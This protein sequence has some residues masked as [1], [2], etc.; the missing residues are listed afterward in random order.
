MC[1]F[2][3]IKE[4]LRIDVLVEKLKENKNVLIDIGIFSL[5]GFVAGYLVKRYGHYMLAIALFIVGLFV[6]QHVNLINI[7]LNWTNVEQ[8]FGIQ[9]SPAVEGGTVLTL[10]WEWVKANVVRMVSLVVGF[11]VGLHVG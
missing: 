8:V 7:S 5:A 3:K 4:T 2:E 1:W 11:L 9:K 10:F 6:L